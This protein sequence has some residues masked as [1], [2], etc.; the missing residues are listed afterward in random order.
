MRR[1]RRIVVAV[2]IAAVAAAAVAGAALA[3]RPATTGVPG[4]FVTI[5]VKLSEKGVTVSRHS[6]SGV[7]VIGFRIRNVGKKA[8]NF[9]IGDRA[10][11]AIKPGQFDDFAVQFD[12]FKTYVYKCTLNCPKSARGTIKVAQGNFQDYGRTRQP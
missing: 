9:V 12:V 5:N 2:A 6:S 1:S 3:L 11:N 7:Q 4:T 10:T 8:H